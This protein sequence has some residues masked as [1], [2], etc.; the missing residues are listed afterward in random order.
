MSQ[1]RRGQA[2]GLA[3]RLWPLLLLLVSLSV[4]TGSIRNRS[5]IPIVQSHVRR[6]VFILILGL[7]R[8]ERYIAENKNKKVNPV[9]R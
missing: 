7:V 9:A 1:G 4:A 6:L 8:P 3:L 2:A 5:K